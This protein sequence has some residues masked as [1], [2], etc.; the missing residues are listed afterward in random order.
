MLS[1]VISSN[2]PKGSVHQ[3]Q[4]GV[5]SQSPRNRNALLHPAGKLK[6]ILFMK[7]LQTHKL[8]QPRRPLPLFGFGENA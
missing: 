4:F 8:E 1:L 6:R 2:A 7:V 3:E 5:E